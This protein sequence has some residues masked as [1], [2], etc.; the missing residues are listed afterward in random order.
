MN[1]E[2]ANNEEP[3]ATE[4]SPVALAQ[5]LERINTQQERPVTA[6]A[7]RKTNAFSVR[8]YYDVFESLRSV[9]EATD[10][11]HH[12]QLRDEI[13]RF[14]ELLGHQPSRAKMD[15]HGSVTVNTI[16]HYLGKYEVIRT[17]IAQSVD[18]RT[19]ENS[20]PRE[21]EEPTSTNDDADG[22]LETVKRNI[23]HSNE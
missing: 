15:R 7:I 3:N 6:T 2:R 22:I 8:Q 17:E 5:E 14:C 4:P 19:D 13:V 20:A 12:Q 10:I 1:N 21:S 18:L 16:E 9:F 23:K 11:N